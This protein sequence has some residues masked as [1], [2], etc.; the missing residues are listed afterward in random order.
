VPEGV[1]RVV[2]HRCDDSDRFVS[3]RSW[4]RIIEGM[5]IFSGE[6][7]MFLWALRFTDSQAK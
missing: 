4:G 5:G 6:A 3:I 7:E 1:G 2:R